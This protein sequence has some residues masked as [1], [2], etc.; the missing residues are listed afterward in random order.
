[1]ASDIDKDIHRTFPSLRR[2]A[3]P[4]GQDSLRRVLQ[5]YAAYDPEVGYC[6]GMNF[7][8]GLLLMYVEE[9]EAACAALVMLMQERGLRKLYGVD[10]QLLQVGERL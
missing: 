5:A 7:V 1:M 4:A 9:E 3:G 2:F 6:Q 8:A 10:M